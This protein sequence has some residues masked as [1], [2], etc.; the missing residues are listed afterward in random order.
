MNMNRNGNASL[1][2]LFWT[3]MGAQRANRVW[4]IKSNILFHST[5]FQSMR[6]FV[7][8]CRDMCEFLANIHHLIFCSWDKWAISWLF[9]WY[10]QSSGMKRYTASR[11]NWNFWMAVST[12]EMQAVVVELKM[13]WVFVRESVQD[14]P[15][16]YIPGYHRRIEI[17]KATNC[18]IWV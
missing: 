12:P 8:F 11:Q 18:T 9:W 6:S 3:E 2:L 1:V 16:V 5:L 13:C 10:K 4:W 7:W 17:V 14:W 15:K